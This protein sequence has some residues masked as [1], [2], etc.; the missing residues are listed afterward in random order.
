MLKWKLFAA[1]AALA[2]GISLLIGAD[3]KSDEFFRYDFSQGGNLELKRKAKIENGVLSLDG[4]GDFASVPGS[5]NM[6]FD[7]KGMTLAATVK[8]NYSETDQSL[9]NKLDMFFSKGNEFI[10]GKFGSQLYFNFHNGKK[11]CAHLLSQEGSVPKSGEWAHVAAVVKYE[12]DPAQGDFGYRVS[13]Y[14]NGEKEIRR[15]FTFAKPIRTKNLIELGK[16]FG[17]GPWFMNGE[18]A[19]AV[20]FNRPLNAAEIARLCSQVP[21]VKAVRKGFTAVN[22][23]L[24]AKADL[25]KARGKLPVQWLAEAFLRAA[26]IGYD[27]NKLLTMADFTV[28][29]ADADIRTL[30]EKFNRISS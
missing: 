4:K 19:N 26:A 24:K 20:M 25:I 2:A 6:H 18:F 5:E 23:E 14:L 22:P 15:K 16:G 29:N 7:K 12:E 28:K 30:S 13:I 1:V 11:W 21:Q 10:F 27:Q 3:L 17:G 8:L 9:N